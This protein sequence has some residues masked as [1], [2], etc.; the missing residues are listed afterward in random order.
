MSAFDGPI[1]RAD[2]ALARF[3]AARE[4]T[5]GWHDE[6]RRRFDEARLGPAD[7]TARKLIAELRAAS[8]EAE[9]AQRVWQQFP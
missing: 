9:R 2:Q 5:A 8:N 6:Q 1:R 3:T 7:H 4:G